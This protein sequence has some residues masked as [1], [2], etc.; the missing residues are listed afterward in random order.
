MAGEEWNET[1]CTKCPAEHYKPDTGNNVTCN[2]CP[3]NETAPDVGYSNCGMNFSL[4]YIEK[5]IL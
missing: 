4:K 3:T 1:H 5:N 2:M